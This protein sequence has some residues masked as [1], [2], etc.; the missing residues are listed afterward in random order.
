M[1][2]IDTEILQEHD[3][4]LR[5]LEQAN[6]KI[7]TKL[8]QVIEILQARRINWLAIVSIA[9]VVIGMIGGLFLFAV[10]PIQNDVQRHEQL[11]ETNRQDIKQHYL[12]RGN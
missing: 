2:P 6:V 8:D 5:V 7:E 4:R 3:S 12:E 10:E 9:L 11:I 1:S